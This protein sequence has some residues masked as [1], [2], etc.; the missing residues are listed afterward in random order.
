MK[1]PT[2]ILINEGEEMTEPEQPSRKSPPWW[3]WFVLM[4]GLGEVAWVG[5]TAITVDNQ[6]SAMQV[7]IRQIQQEQNA[8]TAVLISLQSATQAL[9]VNVAV[10]SQRLADRS[11]R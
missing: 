9:A 5:N 11:H 2:D 10:L 4:I 8:R 7:E 6:I 3:A 1:L